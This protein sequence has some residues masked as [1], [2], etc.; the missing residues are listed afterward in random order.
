MG[1]SKT[2]V[3]TRDGHA[4]TCERIEIVEAAHPVSDAAGRA[5]AECI[6]ELARGAEPDD[7]VP[8]LISGDDSALLAPG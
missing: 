7:L 6:L 5:S 1:C 3:V 4:V 8:C 2:R